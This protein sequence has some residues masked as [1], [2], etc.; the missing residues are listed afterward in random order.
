MLKSQVKLFAGGR[1]KVENSN[2]QIK[3]IFTKEKS[4]DIPTPYGLYF[5]PLP[6]SKWTSMVFRNFLIISK[7]QGLQTWQPSLPYSQLPRSGT[8]NLSPAL[9][10][11]LQR[12][13]RPRCAQ[14]PKA[15]TLHRWRHTLPGERSIIDPDPDPKWVFSTFNHMCKMGAEIALRNDSTIQLQLQPTPCC[16]LEKMGWKINPTDYLIL[17]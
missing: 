12:R 15:H 3:S 6:I 2:N 10:L 14:T 17:A 5:L 8:C 11:I 4:S 1:F 16:Q 13:S 9:K 7:K